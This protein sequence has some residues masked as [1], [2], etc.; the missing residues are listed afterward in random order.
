MALLKKLCLL[1]L[2]LVAILLG[3]GLV[4]TNPDTITID[5]FGRELGPLPR[6]LWLLAALFAGCL[7]G[8]L[9]SLPMLL[10]LRR[11]VH[12]LNQQLIKLR[13]APARAQN[14]TE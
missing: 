6:G 3:I 10:R 9:A 8:V 12:V 5:F 7:M 4:L 1:L 14:K 13:V 11:R 2:G